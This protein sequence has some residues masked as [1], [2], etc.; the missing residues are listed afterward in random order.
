[1][2]IEKAPRKFISNELSID[3]WETIKPYFEELLSRKIE[4]REDFEMWL[5]DRS[6]LDAVIEEDAAWRYIRMTIDTRKE[7]LTESYT[8]FVTKIQPEIAPFEDQLNKKLYSSLFFKEFQN[9]EGY[10]IYLRSV[11]TAIQLFSE[12][13]IPLDALASEKSQQ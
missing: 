4:T 13:N 6:E 8:F 5:E 10:D 9:T 11:E 1:M 2:K 3:S 7:E 12:K